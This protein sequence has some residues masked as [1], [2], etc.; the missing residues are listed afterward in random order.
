MILK[1]LFIYFSSKLVVPQCGISSRNYVAIPSV[2][3]HF[4][5]TP[6]LSQEETL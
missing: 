5:L 2:H 1:Y 3:G 4:A 6:G